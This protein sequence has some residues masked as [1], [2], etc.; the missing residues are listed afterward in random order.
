MRLAAKRLVLLLVEPGTVAWVP[1][2]YVCIPSALQTQQNK[3][4]ADMVPDVAFVWH[5]TIFVESF[6]QELPKKVLG[7]HPNF[8]RPASL[9]SRFEA[10]A[11][12]EEGHFHKVC[13][14]QELSCYRNLQVSTV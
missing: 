8:Q 1:S 6:L 7:R 4:T 3:T 14:S 10:S 11:G 5:F 2:G 13:S 9:L 12:V